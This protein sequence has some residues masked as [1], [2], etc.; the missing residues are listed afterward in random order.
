MVLSGYHS[1]LYASL[2]AD[3]HHTEVAA[4]TGRANTNGRRTE[5]LW[6]NRPL[7]HADTLDFTDDDEEGITAS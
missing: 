1:D 6:S 7:A 5:V 2:Y 4:F 3:W